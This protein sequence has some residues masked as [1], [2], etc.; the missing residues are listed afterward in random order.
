MRVVIVGTGIAGLIA[1]HR[2]S[3]RHEVVLVTKAELTESNTRYAQGGSPPRCSPTTRP[4]RTSPTRSR[5]APGCATPHAVEVLCTEG[6][7]RVRD[8]LSRW[9][10][11]STPTPREHSL[12][13][14]RPRTPPS[15]AAC[16]RRRHRAGDEVAL[17]R[18]VKAIAVEVHEHAFLLTL[19]VEPG[20]DGPR[21]TGSICSGPTAPPSASPPTPWCSP[22]GARGSS[23]PT[24]PTRRH[25]GRRHAAAWRAGAVLSDLSSS[26]STRRRSRFRVTT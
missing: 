18:A 5:R 15:G 1:A 10:S 4:P 16:R 24:P 6:P 23:T 13:G 11:R 14:T 19:V 3:A 17:L 8:P 21:V 20:P 9:A 25:D 12:A 7:E 26:S 22:P 2:A